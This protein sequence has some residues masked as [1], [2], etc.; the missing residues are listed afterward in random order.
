MLTVCN[1]QVLCNTSY[2][3]LKYEYGITNST[4]K[5]YLEKFFPPLQCRNAQHPYQMLKKGEVSISNLLEIIK[6][7]VKKIKVGRPAYLN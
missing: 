2:A 7:S 1:I 6:I 4:L 3:Q 5:I